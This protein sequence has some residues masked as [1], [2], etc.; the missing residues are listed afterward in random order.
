MDLKV[1][2]HVTVFKTAHNS[3]FCCFLVKTVSFKLLEAKKCIEHVLVDLDFGK[4]AEGCKKD[5]ACLK[6]K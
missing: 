2:R 5:S 1:H 6:G 4:W 3:L